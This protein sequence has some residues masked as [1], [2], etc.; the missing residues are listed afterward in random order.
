MKMLATK[1][2]NSDSAVAV[3]W[4]QVSLKIDKTH[5]GSLRETACSLNPGLGATGIQADSAFLSES[6]SEKQTHKGRCWQEL[7]P[8]SVKNATSCDSTGVL[9]NLRWQLQGCRD[10]L[11][12]AVSIT[13]FWFIYLWMSTHTHHRPTEDIMPVWSQGR[14]T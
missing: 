4:T 1:L 10:W 12:V 3:K 8:I 7:W 11:C 14:V 5:A 9:V 13:L 6:L 2:Y